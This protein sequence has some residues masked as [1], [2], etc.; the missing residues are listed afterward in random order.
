MKRYG[1][2]FRI[3]PEFKA[4]YKKAHDE[5]W[6]ELVEA[7]HEAGFRNYSIFFRP[8]GLMFAYYE[9][10]DP[11][12]FEERVKTMTETDVSKRWETAMEKFFVK[13]NY[14]GLGPEIEELE[15]VFHV[16]Y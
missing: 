10:P 2:V 15:E 1:E 14:K 3:R 7:M 12:G 6:P 13:E 8:D 16:D 4:E 9:V 11:D 5:I